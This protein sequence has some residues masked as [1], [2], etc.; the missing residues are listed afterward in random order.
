M[1]D[2]VPLSTCHAPRRANESAS[3]VAHDRYLEMPYSLPDLLY[4]TGE[5]KA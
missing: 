2:R 4:R 3:N 5:C 1:G